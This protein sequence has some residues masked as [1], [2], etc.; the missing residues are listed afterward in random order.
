MRGSTWSSNIS[1]GWTAGMQS[2]TTGHRFVT[3]QPLL[4][5]SL[6]GGFNV[7]VD[8]FV[9]TTNRLLSHQNFPAPV[10]SL[11]NLLPHY[12]GK[13]E[14]WEGIKNVSCQFDESALFCLRSSQWKWWVCRIRMQPAADVPQNRGVFIRFLL[15]VIANFASISRFMNS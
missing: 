1:V 5:T 10:I 3:W 9:Q 6:V 13:I 7:V 12:L 2:F 15:L 4:L 14:K 11:S 8:L